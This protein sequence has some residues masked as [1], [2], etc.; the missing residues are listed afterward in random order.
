MAAFCDLA[1]LGDHGSPDIKQLS[2][3]LRSDPLQMMCRARAAAIRNGCHRCLKSCPPALGDIETTRPIFATIDPHS[4]STQVST[5][6]RA[7]ADVTVC[8]NTTRSNEAESSVCL[9][10]SRRLTDP[11]QSGLS[12][13]RAISAR[14]KIIDEQCVRL[15]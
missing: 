15:R 9:T 1:Y 11:S 3:Q 4:A 14:L 12:T 7:P 2:T 5:K 8:F 6:A 13:S 10:A